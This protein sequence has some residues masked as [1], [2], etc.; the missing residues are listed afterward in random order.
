[1][2]KN[3]IFKSESIS[4]LQIICTYRFH[5]SI[6][7]I[8]TPLL[9]AL[10]YYIFTVTPPRNFLLHRRWLPGN[11]S[12]CSRSCGGGAQIR[13]V[14]CVRRIDEAYSVVH[15]KQCRAP[16]MKKHRKCTNEECPPEW[17]AT[18][19]SKVGMNM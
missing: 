19:W 8:A 9:I 15:P 14:A 17:K 6:A 3:S 16:K 4:N 11:W 2:I 10:H 7:Y 18:S 12:S 5:I 13:K 1:M